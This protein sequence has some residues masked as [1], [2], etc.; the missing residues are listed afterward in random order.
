M[1]QPSQRVIRKRA[2][3]KEYVAQRKAQGLCAWGG[4]PN[5][6]SEGH[7]YCD[8]HL[9]DMVRSQRVRIDTRRAKGLCIACGKGPALGL[10]W[11][12]ACR[13]RFCDSALP[14]GVMR[15]EREREKGEE[16]RVTA[17]RREERNRR[18]NQDLHL[19]DK[20]RQ[21]L[22]ILRYGLRGG[23][24]KTLSEVGRMLGLTRQRVKQLEDQALG[25]INNGAPVP[26]PGRPPR[27]QQ[28]ETLRLRAK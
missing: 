20:R 24:D 7:V 9:K 4:C 16:A 1:S 23:E 17:A 6:F 12:I 3:K 15:S 25:V 18:V 8:A 22:L 2:A 19:L 27:I 10:S 21:R 13:P 26:K 14:R 28:P 5:P 11:C